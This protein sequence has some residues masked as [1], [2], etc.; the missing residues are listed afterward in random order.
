MIKNLKHPVCATCKHFMKIHDDPYMELN[1]CKLF[2]SKNI[3]TGKIHY[4]YAS[5]CRIDHRKCD[6]YGRYWTHKMKEEKS[7]FKW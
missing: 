6:T 1:R 2:G 7:E 3:I 4:D 5:E